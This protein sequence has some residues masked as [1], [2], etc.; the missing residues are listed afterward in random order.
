MG[1]VRRLFFVMLLCIIANRNGII[2]QSDAAKVHQRILPT[3]G[4]HVVE[5]MLRQI[6]VKND[7]DTWKL[8]NG[9]DTN[10]V[11]KNPD[12]VKEF[13]EF[14]EKKREHVVQEVSARRDTRQSQAP[15]TMN[16]A[17]ASAAARQ[18]VKMLNDAKDALANGGMTVVELRKHMQKKNKNAIVREEE[19]QRALQESPAEVVQVRGLWLLGT[20]GKAENDK[21]RSTLQTLFKSKDML[22]KVQILEEYERM[23]AST[24]TLTEY[25][26]RSLLKEIAERTSGDTWVLKGAP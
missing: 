6:A 17:M 9:F 14:F 26:M 11:S 21:F 8:K 10:F 15:N 24:C 1:M 3:T 16:N 25:V 4:K 7:A 18:R 20:T 5:E 23:H 12:V 13:K 19:L 2:N 22:N